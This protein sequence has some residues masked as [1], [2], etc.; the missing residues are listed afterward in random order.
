MLGTEQKG[1][2]DEA[3]HGKGHNDAKKLLLTHALISS[4]D[5]VVEC[6]EGFN[7]Q[8]TIP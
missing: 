5:G 4:S 7:R 1:R 6:S 2:E 8:A 3:E